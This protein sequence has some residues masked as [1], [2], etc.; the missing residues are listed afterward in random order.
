MCLTL[1]LAAMLVACVDVITILFAYEKKNNSGTEID[2]E[3]RLTLS[4]VIFNDL[5]NKTKFI[6]RVRCTLKGN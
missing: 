1:R 4:F 2:I 5:S 3:K 6:L